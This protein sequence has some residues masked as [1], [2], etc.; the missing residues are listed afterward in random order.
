VRRILRTA[1][2]LSRTAQLESGPLQLHGVSLDVRNL[3]ANA[4]REAEQ[5]EGRSSVQVEL[6]LGAQACNAEVDPPWLSVALTELVSQ[7]VRSARRLV[8][9]QVNAEADRVRIGVHDDRAVETALPTTRFVPVRDKRDCALSW[10]L[11]LDIVHAHGGELDLEWV[12]G[13]E[14]ERTVG[15]K[16]WLSLKGV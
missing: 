2:R 15:A 4:V 12:R 6:V 8:Q 11:V 13:G 14:P 1:E 7:A 5:I 10:P 9:V 16:V 3:V